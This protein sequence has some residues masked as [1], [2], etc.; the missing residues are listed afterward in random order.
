MSL[1]TVIVMNLFLSFMDLVVQFECNKVFNEERPEEFQ[2]K[3][4]IQDLGFD[5]W[6]SSYNTLPLVL[7]TLYFAMAPLFLAIFGLLW[8]LLSKQF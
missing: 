1:I 3:Q 2:C 8:Q 5:H 7:L 4:D 6:H